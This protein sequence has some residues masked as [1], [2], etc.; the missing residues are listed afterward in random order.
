V[1]VLAS[2]RATILEALEK[3]LSFSETGVL[4]EDA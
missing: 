1:Q 4:P 2:K 3:Q